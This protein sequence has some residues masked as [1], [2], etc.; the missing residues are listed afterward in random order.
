MR[1]LSGW[2][3]GNFKIGSLEKES[4]YRRLR[5]AIADRRISDGSLEIILQNVVLY[6]LDR[7]RD[8][9]RCLRRIYVLIE[10]YRPALAGK[11]SWMI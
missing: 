4:R 7:R 10:K 11:M 1:G 6:V 5:R 8:F 2:G 9:R 3:F